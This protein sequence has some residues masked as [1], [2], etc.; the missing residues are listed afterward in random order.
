MIDRICL[1]LG[2]PCVVVPIGFK[3]IADLMLQEDILI[4]GEESGGVGVKNHIPER[5]GILISLLLLEAF[6]HS[7]RSLRQGIQELWKEFGEFH[8][9]RAI[10]MCR[11]S[12]ERT[13]WND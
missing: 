9:R 10:C 1:K 7:G 3:N 8:F 6:A 5:D 13:L 12:L 2:L 11:W 4:G